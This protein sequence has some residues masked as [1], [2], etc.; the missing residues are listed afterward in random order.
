[1]PNAIEQS[2]RS[3]YGLSAAVP[4]VATTYTFDYSFIRNITYTVTDG[5]NGND[6]IMPPALYNAYIFGFGGDD[7]ISAISPNGNLAATNLVGGRGADTFV[8][9]SSSVNT[10]IDQASGAVVDFNASEGDQI[11][12][13]GLGYSFRQLVIQRVDSF[14]YTLK[15][16]N[17]EFNIW[18]D[19]NQVNLTSSNVLT[20]PASSPNTNVPGSENSFVSYSTGNFLTGTSVNDS[21]TGQGMHDTISGMSGD[22]TINGGSGNNILNGNIGHDIVNGNA[23]TDDVQ[24]GQGND[25]IHGGH[26]NDTIN[27]NLGNDFVYGDL[28]NDIVHGG[29]GADFL[30][31]G[32][33]NDSLYGDKGN[34][35]ISGEAGA[36]TFYFGLEHSNDV[37]TDFVS[38]TD[39]IALSS[40]LVASADAAI[41]TFFNG[42]LT[43]SA[44]TITLTGVTN[45]Q[46]SD[47]VLF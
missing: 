40:A 33:G 29:Q 32:D 14:H 6:T 30:F 36:D 28:S 12:L 13:R 11:D 23:G 19:P 34:D 27:G 38:G 41:A 35:T 26:H 17:L 1:M 10:S 39:H 15:A 42:V 43:T 5:T 7:R 18:G 47:I 45:L 22:D 3:I 24:G 16:G 46:A 2:L 4:S 8:L 44:G 20:G 21:L 25:T 31:G 37:I 9:G